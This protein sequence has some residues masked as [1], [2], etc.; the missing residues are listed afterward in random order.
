MLYKTYVCVTSPP[1]VLHM[2]H[3]GDSIPQSRPKIMPK[4][5][6]N[7]PKMVHLHRYVRLGYYTTYLEVAE[8]KYRHPVC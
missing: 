2:L 5:L 6:Y 3:M 7:S 8:A 4:S 1:G